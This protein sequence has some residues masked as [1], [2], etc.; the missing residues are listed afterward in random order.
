MPIHNRQCKIPFH[1]PD[2]PLKIA[3]L[4]PE[5]PPNTGN[6]AR[7]CAATGTSLELIGRLG[8]SLSEPALKR[9]GLDYWHA[10]KVQQHASWQAFQKACPSGRRI[11]FSTAAPRS[12]LDELYQP[13]DVLV[14][15]NET[16]GLPDE[17]LETNSE[18]VLGVPI[19]GNLVRSLNLATAA[20]IV[21]FEALRQIQHTL[22]PDK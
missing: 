7:L 6:I 1:W 11:F 21:L 4:E 20:G 22:Q 8:F 3:L 17:L 14:F 2:P 16:R 9:A 19:R 12:Y 13:G 18:M 10:V 15:G 5:I